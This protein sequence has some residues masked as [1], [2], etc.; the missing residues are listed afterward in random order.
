VT[1]IELFG[2]EERS[3]QRSSLKREGE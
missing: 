3:D 1:S 2:S